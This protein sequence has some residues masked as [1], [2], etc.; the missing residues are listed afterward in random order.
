MVGNRRE[1]YA[2]LFRAG[3]LVVVAFECVRALIEVK[4]N[5]TSSELIDALRHLDGAI[6]ERRCGPP[7]FRGVFGFKGATSPTLISAI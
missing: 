3:N 6:G 1:V 7:V 2:P 5:L 4:S